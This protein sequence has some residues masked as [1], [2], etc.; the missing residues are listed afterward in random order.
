MQVNAL[1]KKRSGTRGQKNVKV[2]AYSIHALTFT[3]SLQFLMP[4]FEYDHLNLHG[5]FSFLHQ[6][7]SHSPPFKPILFL[8][9][10][11]PNYSY[12]SCPWWTYIVYVYRLAIEIQRCAVARHYFLLTAG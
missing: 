6:N 4:E 2:V 3:L 5:R 9:S 7:D 1:C 8:L 10:E 12:F 11:P